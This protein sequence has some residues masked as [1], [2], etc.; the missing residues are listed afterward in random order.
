M[1]KFLI[2]TLFFLFAS[3]EALGHEHH[4]DHMDEGVP[5][6][7]RD[8]VFNLKEKWTD[9]NGEGF[10]L[11][12]LA[13]APTLIAMTYTHCKASCP[14]IIEDMRKIERD[15]GAEKVHMVMVSFDSKRDTP[16][17]LK[18]FA[19]ERKLDPPH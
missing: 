12:Q 9:Q 18:K 1:L 13:G 7:S 10:R 14:L 8:S 4:S 5:A 11:T 17:E 6:P 3:Y 2:A 19:E 16:D 15:S